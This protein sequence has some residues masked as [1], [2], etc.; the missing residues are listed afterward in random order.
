MVL[1]SYL[2]A[3]WFSEFCPLVFQDSFWVFWNLFLLFIT[4]KLFQPYMAFTEGCRKGTLTAIFP[5][6]FCVLLVHITLQHF[7]MAFLLSFLLSFS[8]FSCFL[9]KTGSN[10]GELK[11]FKWTSSLSLR[12]LEDCTVVLKRPW[13]FLFTLNKT[14][15]DIICGLLAIVWG[16]MV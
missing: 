9:R 4:E 13:T 12:W 11:L 14:G 16:C 7:Q 1:S 15:T 2:M 5:L 8:K 10:V 6:I 3:V